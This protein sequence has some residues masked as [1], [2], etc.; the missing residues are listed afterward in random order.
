M[1]TVAAINCSCTIPHPVFRQY[2]TDD[3]LPSSETYSLL[4]DN[5]G[6]IWAATDNG[7]SRFDGYEFRNFSV[8]DGLA[9]STI[10]QLRLDTKGRVW[11]Q[12]MSG[13]LYIAEGV[14]IKPWDG[15]HLIEP[16]QKGA[17]LGE[18]FMVAAASAAKA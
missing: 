3:G 11:I 9:E 17:F 7:V 2:T 13:N 4:Q 14:V 5:D 8:K 1:D 16:Y 18:G 15:N 10:F 12:A 6:Y